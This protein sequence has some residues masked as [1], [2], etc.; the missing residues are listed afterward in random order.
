MSAV[1][2]FGVLLLLLI[3]CQSKETVVA[4]PVVKGETIYFSPEEVLTTLN[5]L[6]AIIDWPADTIGHQKNLMVNSESAKKLMLPLHPLYDEKVS[7]VAGLIPGWDKD[8]VV[9]VI[10]NCAKKCECD[11]YQE[12]LDRNPQ[13]LENA[14]PELKNFA[15]Q[16][17]IKTKESVLACLQNMSSIQILLNY[18]RDEQKN[19][20]AESVL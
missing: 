17:I 19:Y 4:S 10:S 20:E 11:F 18:L 12:V 15:G 1:I 6:V 5:V 9:S 16:K 7:E 2:Q 8:K 13:L 3:S 14:I